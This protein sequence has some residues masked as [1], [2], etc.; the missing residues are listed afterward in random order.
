MISKVKLGNSI[1][2]EQH[3][4]EQEKLSR[5]IVYSSGKT[6]GLFQLL[7]ILG[8]GVQRAVLFPF[9]IYLFYIFKEANISIAAPVTTGS[10]GILVSFSSAD[11]QLF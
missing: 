4:I 9:L 7:L 1:Q 5:L 10:E 6:L 3:A 2:S 8:L 11:N